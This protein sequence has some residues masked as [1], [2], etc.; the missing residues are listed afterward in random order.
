VRAYGKRSVEEILEE[1]LETSRQG[2]AD[3]RSELGTLRSDMNDGF[4]AL[5]TEMIGGLGQVRKEMRAGLAEVRLEIV[6]VRADVTRRVV[7]VEVHHDDLDER[8][9]RLE[10]DVDKLKGG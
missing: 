7:G 9:A 6:G 10:A 1:H 8:V 2:F 5:R 4:R 3:L